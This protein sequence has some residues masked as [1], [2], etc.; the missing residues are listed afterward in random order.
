MA[1]RSWCFHSCRTVSANPAVRG[2]DQLITQ[3]IHEPL[4]LPKAIAQAG[5]S[6]WKNS[7]G[8]KKVLMLSAFRIRNATRKRRMS[9]EVACL[10][11]GPKVCLDK[12]FSSSVLIA[13]SL[14]ILVEA[15]EV[16]VDDIALS[17]HVSQRGEAT[18]KIPRINGRLQE[19]DR[20]DPTWC[21]W[22]SPK[23]RAGFTV[24]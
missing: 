20:L 7:S 22:W 15:S 4:S 9:C 2:A 3:V 10:C 19:V 5:S 13:E 11:A 24:L 17:N 18:G 1:D 14:P 16:G 12:L 8:W 21:T 6:D 23:A